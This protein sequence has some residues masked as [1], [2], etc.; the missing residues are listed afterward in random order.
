MYGPL[1]STTAGGRSPNRGTPLPLLPKGNPL[2]PAAQSGV[3]PGR[4]PGVDVRTPGPLGSAVAMPWP[5]PA[6]TQSPASWLY[7]SWAGR[8]AVSS[9]KD[10][11]AQARAV[12]AQA[13]RPRRLWGWHNCSALPGSGCFQFRLLRHTALLV[14]GRNLGTSRPILAPVEKKISIFTEGHGCARAGRSAL[15][16]GA[17]ALFAVF[18]RGSSLHPELPKASLENLG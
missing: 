8:E 15:P 5:R 1:F 12:S 18:P 11:G 14:V 3:P 9:E 10:G 16:P 17:H 4:G 7:K 6:A 2:V 13:F